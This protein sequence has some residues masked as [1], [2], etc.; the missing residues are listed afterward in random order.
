MTGPCLK[1]LRPPELP[2]LLPL[3]PLVDVALD[4]LVD[5][6]DTPTTGALGGVARFH[7]IQLA[8]YSITSSARATSVG[9]TA[10]PSVFAVLRLT[11]SSNFTGDCT[12]SVA[13]SS[14][15]RIRST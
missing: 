14:P 8:L 1:D 2:V 7:R 13:G 15:L 10:M 11:T 9:G 3:E 6:P 4:P 12:G 5:V